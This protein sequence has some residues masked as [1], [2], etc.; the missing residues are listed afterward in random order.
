MSYVVSAVCYDFKLIIKKHYIRLKYKYNGKIP[1]K[2]IIVI[3]NI[4]A[5][6]KPE[7]AKVVVV[8]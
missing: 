5:A 2:K 6:T 4:F 7:S 3:P 8:D 1:E